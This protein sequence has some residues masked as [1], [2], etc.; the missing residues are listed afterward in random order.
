[1]FSDHVVPVLSLLLSVSFL[2]T[3]NLFHVLFL[4]MSV[5]LLFS[6][7][8]VPV[9]SLLLSVSLGLADQV[10]YSPVFLAVCQSFACS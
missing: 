5:I 3:V 7:P 9:L 2:L 1:M 6:D 4:L 10:V 8:V